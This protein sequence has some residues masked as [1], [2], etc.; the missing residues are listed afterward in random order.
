MEVIGLYDA[1]APIDSG[2]ELH[3]PT[4]QEAE[5]GWALGREVCK[6]ECMW[7]EW[8][9]YIPAV[10]ELTPTRGILSCHRVLTDGH[11][12]YEVPYSKFYLNCWVCGYYSSTDE[13]F[14]LPSQIGIQVTKY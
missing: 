13:Y 1:P 3:E 8:N 11:V 10:G 2:K 5:V 14:S 9:L 7:L 6:K 4:A 12:M